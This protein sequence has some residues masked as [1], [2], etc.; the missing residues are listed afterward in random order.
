MPARSRSTAA[1]GRPL[2]GIIET[3]RVL[4]GQELSSPAL[5]ST[6]GMRAGDCAP[7]SEMADR[8]A[9]KV[10]GGIDDYRTG[11]AF[12]ATLSTA[13]PNCGIPSPARARHASR[14]RRRP[15]PRAPAIG[16]FRCACERLRLSC[17][18]SRAIDAADPGHQPEFQA[19]ICVPRLNRAS[20]PNTFGGSSAA[21]RFDTAVFTAAHNLPSAPARVSDPVSL[22]R[23]G[24]P[25]VLG[26][27]FRMTERVRL[28]FRKG[29]QFNPARRRSATPGARFGSAGFGTI[30]Q[31][32]QTPAISSFEPKLGSGSTS[33][34][35][36]SRPFN[37]RSA[38]I[39]PGA[40]TNQ[41][42]CGLIRNSLWRTGPDVSCRSTPPRCGAPA[43]SG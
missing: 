13:C 6:S 42:A 26:K 21:G 5:N 11:I 3:C 34:R 37:P 27:T 23:G 19:G 1:T 28:E 31:R 16:R 9:E 12:A 22:G 40:S 14:L 41:A 33:L 15:W 43:S 36:P 7:P 30:T 25:L 38:P 29:V 18:S 2:G 39:R 24:R 20:N 17:G 35:R 32:Q 8:S 10:A 4:P